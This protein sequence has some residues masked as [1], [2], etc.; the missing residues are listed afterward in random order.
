MNKTNKRR[1][2]QDKEQG[3]EKKKEGEKIYHRWVLYCQDG[4][5][6]FEIPNL[7]K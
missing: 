2:L 1:K 7:W 3:R 6:L 5:P 4:T